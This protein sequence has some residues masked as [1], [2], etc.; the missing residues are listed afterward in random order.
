M[1]AYIKIIVTG[2]KL[3]DQYGQSLKYKLHIV[4]PLRS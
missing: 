4:R 3:V 2:F 1:V